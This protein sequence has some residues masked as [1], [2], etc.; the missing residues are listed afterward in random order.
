MF[1]Q[2]GN[3]VFF[4]KQNQKKV[5]SKNFFMHYYFA[6]AQRPGAPLGFP[7]QWFSVAIIRDP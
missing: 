2:V 6:V 5:S 7:D 4:E 1:S 3:V